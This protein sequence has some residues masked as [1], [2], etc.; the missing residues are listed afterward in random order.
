MI[1]TGK[2]AISVD[3]GEGLWTVWMDVTP[4]PQVE[5]NGYACRVVRERDSST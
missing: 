3:T 2:E 5:K 4:V 1:T